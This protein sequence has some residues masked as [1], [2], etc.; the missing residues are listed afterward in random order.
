MRWQRK[1]AIARV[2]A[3]LPFGEHLYRAGQRRFG[4]LRAQPAR[5]LGAQVEMARWLS[6]SGMGVEGRDFFEVGTGH[7]PVVP[8]GFFLSGA[9]QCITVDLHRRIDW[10]LTRETL[11]W[12]ATHQDELGALYQQVTRREVFRERLARL[13]E[14]RDKPTQFFDQAAVRYMAP[15]D[16]AHT[17]LASASLDCHFSMTV[18]EHVAPPA[19]EGILREARR[20]LKPG[21]AALHFIDPGDH[22][23]HS[24]RSISAI[25]FLRYSARDWQRVAGNEFAYCNRLRAS[26]FLSMAARVGF[27]AARTEIEVDKS[28]KQLLA[29]SFPLDSGF[30]H[31]EVDDLCATSLR[32]LWT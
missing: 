29:Q 6:S 19:L 10:D 16:A 8:I 24:D 27:C 32:V 2:C 20:I 4:E 14:L 25:N 5:R 18:L 7:I 13:V 21:G 23:A 26:D 17:G 31:Y 1:A 12:I 3:Q 11:H 30:R 15:R 28:A 9:R 22:F